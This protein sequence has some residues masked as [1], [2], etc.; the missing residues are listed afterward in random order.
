[1][2]CTSLAL[3]TNIQGYF[4][5]GTPFRK[6]FLRGASR[7][8]IPEPFFSCHQYNKVRHI[9]LSYRSSLTNKLAQRPLKFQMV[10]ANNSLD[11]VQF[12]GTLPRSNFRSLYAFQNLFFFFFR[13][14]ALPNLYHK[15]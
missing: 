2:C 6:L 10:T 4:C 15:C 8:G 13:K 5:D 9:L 11:F 1:M 3:L 7:N 14:I 12:L